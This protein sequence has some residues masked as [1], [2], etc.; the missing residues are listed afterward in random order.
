MT[1]RP[2]DQYHASLTRER[3]LEAAVA[4]A[5][6]AGLPALT[7]RA[8]AGELGVEAMSLYHHVPNKNA[9]LDGIVDA[10]IT[11]INAATGIAD[12]PEPTR[13]WRADL[14]ETVLT[15][16]GVLLRHPWAPAL[17]PT[18][19]SLSLPVVAYHEHVLRLM[20]EGGFSYDLAHHALHALGSRALGF[21]QE[22]FQPDEA[23]GEELP[24]I[25]A[26]EFPHLAGMLTESL[27][28]DG[29]PSLGWCDDQKEFEFAL[30]L[31]LDGLERLRV[32]EAERS[33]P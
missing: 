5:D 6:R 12:R 4:L 20:R 24:D 25:P 29:G 33:R 2:R 28:A 32:A 26:E 1:V 7:M 13:D 11:E 31:L 8:L 23:A 3:V 22:L 16:R 30:D 15:A 21:A 17:I 14:R 19:A 10:V 18:R 9:L 27:H